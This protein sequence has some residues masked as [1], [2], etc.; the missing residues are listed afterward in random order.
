MPCL[1]CDIFL[2]RAEIMNKLYTAHFENNIARFVITDES[3]DVYVSKKDISNILLS[4]CTPDFKSIFANFFDNVVREFLDTYDKRGAVLEID[5]IG[6][7]V[8]FHAIGNILQVLGD[9]HS[10]SQTSRFKENSYRFNAVSKWYLQASIKATNE[11][12]VSLQ[13]FLVSVKNRLDRY[14]PPFVVSVTHTDGMWIAENDDLGL[15]TEAKSYDALT[16]RVW[17]IAPELAELNDLGV[18]VDEMRISFQHIEKPPH[19]IA[20]G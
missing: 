11:L 17:K 9:V 19:M 14:N 10:E 12:D 18:D 1:A 13:D 7:V 15:V 3:K 8:H 2:W 16:E 6:P 5:T 4:V 20:A